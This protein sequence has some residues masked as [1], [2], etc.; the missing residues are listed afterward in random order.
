MAN[1]EILSEIN[2]SLRGKT[3]SEILQN[4]ETRLWNI[5][6]IDRWTQENK[7]TYETLIELQKIYRNIEERENKENGKK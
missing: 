2:N 7:E 6:M 5:N 3:T 4:I 1:I